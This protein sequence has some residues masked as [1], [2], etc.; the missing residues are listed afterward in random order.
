MSIFNFL[1]SSKSEWEQAQEAYLNHFFPG[2]PD[3]VRFKENALRQISNGKLAGGKALSLYTK[4]KTDFKS[5]AEEFNGR[6][7]LGP[8][9]AGLL[10]SVMGVS[11]S[12]L[13]PHEASG[14]LHYALLDKVCQ[15]TNPEGPVTSFLN[16]LFGCDYVGCDTDVIPTGFGEFGYEA[17]N[18]VPVRGIRSNVIYLGELR[19]PNMQR[20]DFKR[21]RSIGVE[22]IAGNVDEYELGVA[23]KA[24]G[25][26]YISP[27]HRRISERPPNFMILVRRS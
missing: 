20:V 4:L 8:T 14:V 7:K 13:S 22:N 10:K 12:L 24:V 25:Y 16:S 11:Q 2:G 21:I 19:S 1:K 18:P 26:L 5:Q 3:E 27:Y 17:T 23:G 9:F 6:T 15:T